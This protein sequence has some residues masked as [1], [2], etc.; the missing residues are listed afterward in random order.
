MPAITFTNIL[1]DPNNAIGDAGQTGGSSGPGYSSVTLSSEHEIMNTRTNSGRLISRELAGH[2]WDIGISYNPMIREDFE[3]VYS[4]LLQKRGSFS[5]FFVSLPQ[6]K[7]PRDPSFATFVATNTFLT[8]FAGAAGTT[9]LMIDQASYVRASNGTP[10]PG[11][12]FTITDAADS[13]HTKTYQVTRIETADAFEE[14]VTPPSDAS[15]QLRIHFIPAL[16]RSVSNDAEIN[17]DNPLFRVIMK[18]DVQEYSLNSDNLYSFSL[19]LEE[20]QK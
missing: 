15:K 12:V 3:P 10:R 17:F 8:A 16:Q 13:N 20:A 7:A 1:P 11:D 18:S 4:F 5:P 14:N 9:N 2:K 19:K 6:Y